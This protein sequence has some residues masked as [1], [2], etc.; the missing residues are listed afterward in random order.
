MIYGTLSMPHRQ[1]DCGMRMRCSLCDDGVECRATNPAMNADSVSLEWFAAARW[2]EMDLGSN[3]GANMGHHLHCRLSLRMYRTESKSAG[4]IDEQIHDGT[5]AAVD[6]ALAASAH[7]NFRNQTWCTR[8][9]ESLYV[10]CGMA[11]SGLWYS[12]A[13]S[14]CHFWKT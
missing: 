4:N 14:L 13:S 12:F 3:D 1:C 10:S 8:N 2:S 5:I 6:M 9:Q 7:R 11:T